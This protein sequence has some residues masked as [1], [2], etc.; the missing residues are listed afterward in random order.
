[1]NGEKFFKKKPR[2]HPE[3][4]RFWPLRDHLK[5]GVQRGQNACDSRHFLSPAGVG[6]G[7]KH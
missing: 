3:G 2:L 1:M 6:A 7:E 5:H 4:A